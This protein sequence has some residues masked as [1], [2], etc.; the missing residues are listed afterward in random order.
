M[1]TTPQEKSAEEETPQ[2][3]LVQVDVN[4]TPDK[5]TGDIDMTLD[6]VNATLD[7]VNATLN[8]VDA[9]L[10]NVNVTLDKINAV[11]DNVDAMLDNINV[12]D[13]ADN[14]SPD[15]REMTLS[16]LEH[17]TVWRDGAAIEFS[18]C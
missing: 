6:D 17:C 11:L 18:I 14:A 12:T 3:L 8:N 1:P 5:A 4:A 7:N 10:D 9:K 13:S 16:L 2:E 15:L